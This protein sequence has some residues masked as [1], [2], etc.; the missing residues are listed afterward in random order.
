MKALIKALA[1]RAGLDVMSLAYSRDYIYDRFLPGALKG[2]GI[3]AVIDIGANIGGYGELL[4]RVGFAGD[5]HSFEPCSQPF[6]ELARKAA[7]DPRWHVYQ[8]AASDRSG[9][10]QI[11][12]MVGSEL[13]SFLSPRESSRKMTE[14]GTEDVETVTLDGLDLPKAWSPTF[15]KID[16][17]GHDVKVMSGGRNVLRQAALIQSEVSFLPIYQGM[18]AFDEAIASLKE[19]GFDVIGMFP[20]SRDS[21]GRVQEF[22][23]LCVNRNLP[24]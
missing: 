20:V 23:C 3:Q 18:P 15:V 4:R 16:T 5:I 13:N 19:L 7:G 10:A 14:T 24:R 21:L 22:D 17:Q 9:T 8:K 6:G 1:H 2:H 11:H 12:T